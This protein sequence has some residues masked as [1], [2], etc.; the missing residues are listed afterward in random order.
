MTNETLKQV[1]IDAGIMGS[2]TASISVWM[3][4]IINP[5]LTGLVL[6]S[7]VILTY[8]RIKAIKK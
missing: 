4:D 7:A 3:T 6:L 5:I 1:A 8:Y 2:W